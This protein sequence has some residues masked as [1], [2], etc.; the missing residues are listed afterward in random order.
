M[1]ATLI[2]PASSWSPTRSSACWRQPPQPG[3]ALGATRLEV[4]QQR[5]PVAVEVAA[6]AQAGGSVD[7]GDEGALLLDDAAHAADDDAL[8]V[9]QVRQAVAGRPAGVQLGVAR[10]RRQAGEQGTQHGGGGADDG[11]DGGVDD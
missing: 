7:R 11:E 4:G 3:A 2:S 9:E 8:G 5:S 1:S 10:L 6:V